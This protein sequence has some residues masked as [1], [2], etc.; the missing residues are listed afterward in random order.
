M[1]YSETILTDDNFDDELEKLLST[2]GNYGIEYDGFVDKLDDSFEKQEN[3]LGFEE[4]IKITKGLH[5]DISAMHAGISQACKEGKIAYE[6]GNGFII[7]N[8]VDVL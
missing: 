6:F 2:I 8:F 3:D 7:L 1:K 4:W 5:M